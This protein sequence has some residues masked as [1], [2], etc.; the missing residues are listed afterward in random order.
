MPLFGIFEKLFIPFR[1]PKAPPALASSKF[2]KKKASSSERV[3]PPPSEGQQ[4]EPV[5]L[6]RS[7]M[8]LKDACHDRGI[9]FCLK[10]FLNDGVPTPKIVE[11]TPHSFCVIRGRVSRPWDLSSG[12][13]FFFP[14]N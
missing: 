2:V 3:K 11:N 7:Y 1:A 10:Q 14:S 13:V 8:S 9:I 6:Y 5:H 4:Q 12:T